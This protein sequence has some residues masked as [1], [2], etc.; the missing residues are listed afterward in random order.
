[1]TIKKQQKSAHMYHGIF[2]LNELYYFP[3][4][5]ACQQKTPTRK[6]KCMLWPTWVVQP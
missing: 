5:K 2:L 1:M 3:W 6:K 4:L